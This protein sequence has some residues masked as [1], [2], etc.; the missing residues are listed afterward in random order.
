M[1]IIASALGIPLASSVV[2]STGSTATSYSAPDSA[3]HL[4]AVVQHGRFV[5][6]ALSDDDDT[7]EGD[8]LQEQSHLVD[9]GPIARFLWPLPAQRPA[10]M[11]AA[12]VTRMRS[13]PRFRSRS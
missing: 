3:A 6:L 4:L 13:K 10:A 7:A 5:F 11:A 9:G 8:G 2:P 1:A 12:S